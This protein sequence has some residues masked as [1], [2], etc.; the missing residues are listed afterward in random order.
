MR[1]ARE[2]IE[3]MARQKAENAEKGPKVGQFVLGSVKCFKALYD[4]ELYFF[5]KITKLLQ[6][7]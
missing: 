7:C 3:R 2:Y 5:Q 6:I 1:I 4:K